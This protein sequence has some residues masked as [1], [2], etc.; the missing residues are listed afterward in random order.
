MRQD[1]GGQ[2][3]EDRGMEDRLW[4]SQDSTAR[5]RACPTNDTFTD[6]GVIATRP[7]PWSWGDL[8]DRQTTGLW[9]LLGQFV[10]HLNSAYAWRP[11]H[12]TPPCWAEHPAVVQELTTLYWSRWAAFES[13]GA[14]PEAAQTWHQ[15]S[16]PGYLDRLRS[17]VG[18]AALDSCRQGHHQESPLVELHRGLDHKHRRSRAEAE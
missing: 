14:T 18:T 15:W 10:D 9:W 11:E 13:A 7:W 5:L 1:T 2:G 3:M 8:D 4:G 17:W 6:A 16:L 12:V